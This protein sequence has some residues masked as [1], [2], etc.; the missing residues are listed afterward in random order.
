MGVSRSAGRVA[1][2]SSVSALPARRFASVRLSGSFVVMS[3]ASARPVRARESNTTS[4]PRDER[5]CLPRCHPHSAMP[6]SVTDG[7]STDDPSPTDRRCPLSLALC[8]GAYLPR[9]LPL[10]SVRRLPGPFTA[11]VAPVS[12]SH[13]LSVPTC[14]G[15][16][17]R[18]LPVLRDVAGSMESVAG[19]VKR[20]QDRADPG[21]VHRASASRRA[22][23]RPRRPPGPAPRSRGAFPA[24]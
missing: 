22:T 7:P 9:P 2:R 3:V 23:R 19:A 1:R 8:A 12:T 4:R 5:S 17:S 14:D 11:V 10:R 18:S 6:H 20:G 21:R 15:Y 24:P 13:R 16:S